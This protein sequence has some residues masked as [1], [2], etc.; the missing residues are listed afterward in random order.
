VREKKSESLGEQKTNRDWGRGDEG[1]L[2]GLNPAA[3][4][5]RHCLRQCDGSVLNLATTKSAGICIC[6]VCEL[7]C[8]ISHDRCDMKNIAGPFLR[9]LRMN[10]LMS[11]EHRTS[12]RF[13]SAYS[14]I[15]MTR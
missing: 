9:N 7:S 11:Q 1:S 6:Y 4:F 15:E 5:Q 14:L 2:R 3:P 12:I 13:I 10:Q 8:I